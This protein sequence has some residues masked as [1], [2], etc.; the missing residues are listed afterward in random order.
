MA[1][2]SPAPYHLRSFSRAAVAKY[3]KRGGGGLQQQ[4]RCIVLPFGGQTSEVKMRT[5]PHPLRILP[6]LF[7]LLLFAT[8]SL[9]SLAYRCTAPTT[10]TF[11][12]VSSH[13]LP[14]Y[15]SISVSKFPLFRRT[16][17]ILIAP[18][19]ITLFQKTFWDLQVVSPLIAKISLFSF[20]VLFLHWYPAWSQLA[21][22]A[23][24]LHKLESGD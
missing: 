8:H 1:I 6:C 5:G 23:L 2:P 21:L 16:P 14:V 20:F 7:W 9:C 17:D 4:R 24:I 19:W 18:M 3:H 12:R 15:V 11:S 13:H 22:A 10:A